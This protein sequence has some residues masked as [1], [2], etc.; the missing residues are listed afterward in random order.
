MDRNWKWGR[1]KRRRWG[2]RESKRELKLETPQYSTIKGNLQGA[3]PI[4]VST[5][6]SEE[7]MNQL[8]FSSQQSAYSNV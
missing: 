1:E 3:V 7:V 8:H 4:S 5:G 6:F 2:V